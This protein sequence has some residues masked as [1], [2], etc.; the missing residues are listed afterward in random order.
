MSVYVPFHCSLFGTTGHQLFHY[1]MYNAN[2]S[3]LNAG[4]H[5]PFLKRLLTVRMSEH[6]TPGV[7]PRAFHPA[8]GAI[9]STDGPFFSK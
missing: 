6:Q 7:L 5:K 2:D 8:L 3:R 4:C 1:S 9:I